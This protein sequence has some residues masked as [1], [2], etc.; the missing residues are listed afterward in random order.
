MNAPYRR[1]KSGDRGRSQHTPRHLKSKYSAMLPGVDVIE[2]MKKEMADLQSKYRRAKIFLYMVIHDLKHPAESLIST[3]EHVLGKF[4]D[5]R[6]QLKDLNS[7]SKRFTN[8]FSSQ[9][10]EF[11]FRSMD[12][13]QSYS[14]DVE[15]RPPL[16]H[17]SDKQA[18]QRMEE[19]KLEESIPEQRVPDSP[20]PMRIEEEENKDSPA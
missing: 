1:S 6:R 10:M 3:V 7:H 4:D 17:Q 18:P 20:Q 15:F 2:A 5:L 11:G 8:N 14:L 12:S 16:F 9:R 19:V 13:S